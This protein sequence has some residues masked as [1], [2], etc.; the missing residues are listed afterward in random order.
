MACLASSSQGRQRGWD[1][2][3]DGAS[4]Y[5][6]FVL[7]FNMLLLWLQVPDKAVA[8]A[9]VAFA[10]LLLVDGGKCVRLA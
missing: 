8:V 6:L 10:L 7:H 1:F 5:L 3:V 9:A 4:Q 2:C